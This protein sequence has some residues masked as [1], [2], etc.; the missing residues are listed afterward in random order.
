MADDGWEEVT[1]PGEMK[2]VLGAQGMRSMMGSGGAMGDA[3][4]T[5]AERTMRAKAK[6]KM[7]RVQSV[8]RQLKRVEKLYNDHFKGIGPGSIV[9]YFPTPRRKKLDAAANNLRPLLKPLIRDP[10][11][12]TFTD[13][14]QALL[15]SLIPE[16][17][18]QDSDN[19]E[20]M[21]G[22][23]ALI[24]DVRSQYEQQY[25]QQVTPT[26]KRVR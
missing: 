9:E 21:M 8:E 14:D 23:Q 6:T 2:K 1:D 16:G 10:G 17:G 22:I 12:G 5:A 4:M 19:E 24:G 25:G 13:Q 15:D 3:G 18:K 20:R 7:L 11:E 26:I